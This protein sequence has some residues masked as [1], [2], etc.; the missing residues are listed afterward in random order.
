MNCSE[1]FAD[2]HANTYLL[3]MIKC[4]LPCLFFTT[5]ISIP[6][7]AL[8]CFYLQLW[9]ASD[10]ATEHKWNIRNNFLPWKL[11]TDFISRSLEK[12]LG[13]LIL[14]HQSCPEDLDDVTQHTESSLWLK[15]KE[16]VPFE[17]RN[18]KICTPDPLR[19]VITIL[20]KLAI[21]R[22]AGLSLG[23]KMKGMA[24]WWQVSMKSDISQPSEAFSVMR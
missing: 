17:S 7:L 4:T 20:S 23:S 21:I 2:L 16:W 10:I 11:C 22:P 9:L 24:K 8:L 19:A 1:Q 13:F 5:S 18:F 14:A 6:A 3:Y 15:S 12:P